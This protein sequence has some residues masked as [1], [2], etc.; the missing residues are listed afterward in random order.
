[1]RGHCTNLPERELMDCL[2][3]LGYGIESK[4]GPAEAEVGI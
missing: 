1:M 2:A 3:R 4:A